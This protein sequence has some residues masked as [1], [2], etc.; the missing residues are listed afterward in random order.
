M[1]GAAP[2]ADGAGTILYFFKD[3]FDFSPLKPYI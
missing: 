1:R 2:K 3:L